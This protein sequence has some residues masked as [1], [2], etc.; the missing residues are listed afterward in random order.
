[1]V[2]FNGGG[3]IEIKCPQANWLAL[4]GLK[5]EVFQET[6]RVI[7]CDSVEEHL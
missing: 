6:S 1:M 7:L 3:I 4:T 2:K 5:F